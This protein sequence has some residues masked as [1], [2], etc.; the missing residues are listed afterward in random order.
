[1][2]F[3]RYMSVLLLVGFMSA[4][5]SLSPSYEKPQ[6]NITSFS[7]APQSNGLAPRFIIGLQVINPNRDSLS[8]KGMSYSVEVENNRILSG[9]TADL[10]EVAGYGMADFTIQASPDLLG[11]A[12]LINQLLNGQN[13]SLDY[14][15]KAKLDVGALIPFI[16]IEE[17][18]KLSLSE[19]R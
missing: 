13:D 14:T 11:G 3:L 16:H 7:L 1:M 19:T 4:C 6:V 2:K 5:A 17:R 9:A 15:F 18:G 8:L 10:P 12:R